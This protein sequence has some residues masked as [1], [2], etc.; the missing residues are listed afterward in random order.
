MFQHVAVGNAV[1][2]TD[3]LMLPVIVFIGF[4]NAHGRKTCFVKRPVMP[5]TTKTVE[6]IHHHHIQIGHIQI[7]HLI[8][9]ARQ[10]ARRRIDFPT[11]GT[12]LS[13]FFGG[14]GITCTF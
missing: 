2:N 10:I 13:S 12:A 9:I 11:L 8:D 4:H 14:F 6:T 5:A 3:V 7:C 1:F